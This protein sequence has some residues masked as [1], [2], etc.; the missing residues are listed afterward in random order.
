MIYRCPGQDS[1]NV[2]VST[3]V[4]PGCRYEVEIFSDEIRTKC[5][6]CGDCVSKERL[7]SCVD[8]CGSARYCLSSED[9]RRLK[10]GQ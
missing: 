9:F 6:G 3:V 2:E 1:R 8:W 5:P 4:C 7:P 10:G